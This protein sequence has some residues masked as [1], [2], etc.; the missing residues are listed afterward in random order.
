MAPRKPVSAGQKLRRD[1]DKTLKEASK[2]GQIWEWDTRELALLALIESQADTIEKLD[3]TI[4][5]D[6]LTAT[7]STGQMRL[8]PAVT[9]VRLAR[10]ALAKLLDQL[11][12]PEDAAAG[13]A[14]LSPKSRQHAK[15]ANSRWDRQKWQAGKS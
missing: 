14:Q 3:S 6:G 8:H 11:Q 1:L 12:L 4:A 7:G 2:D 15:A 13:G 5:T 10:S 9:E